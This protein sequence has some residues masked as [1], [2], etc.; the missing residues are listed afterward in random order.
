LPVVVNSEERGAYGGVVR[1]V[2]GC[3]ASALLGRSE[4]EPHGS[5]ATNAVVR[6][7]LLTRKANS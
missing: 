4:P 7:V 2:P 1:S 5:P 3:R 6:A